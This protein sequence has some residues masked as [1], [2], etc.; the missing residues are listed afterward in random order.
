[1]GSRNSAYWGV[2]VNKKLAVLLSDRSRSC[3]AF[4][5][6]YVARLCARKDFTS[7]TFISHDSFER[8]AVTFSRHSSKLATARWLLCGCTIM[9]DFICVAHKT[10][11]YLRFE[12]RII[13][14]SP[15]M[16]LR[17]TILNSVWF[18]TLSFISTYFCNWIKRCL[19]IFVCLYFL[20]SFC[21]RFMDL[22][23]D[24]WRG[25]RHVFV[26]ILY[27]RFVDMAHEMQCDII[28]WNS[29]F[30]R[31]GGREKAVAFVCKT[32]ASQRWLYSSYRRLSWPG[33]FKSC[34]DTSV[35]TY[36]Y[37]TSF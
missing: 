32:S 29:R 11:A 16:F 18:M 33:C 14:L 20:R 10:F 7:S 24:T 37:F 35:V 28:F 12:F 17:I 19:E 31:L 1:M 3:K 27:A 15:K 9:A 13:C 2:T 34:L 8:I 6:I 30:L 4:R 5:A 21:I 23:E 36:E 26:L 25:S 22:L